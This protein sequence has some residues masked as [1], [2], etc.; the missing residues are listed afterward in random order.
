[1]RESLERS[2][3]A[4]GFLVGKN[5][6]REARVWPVL[7]SELTG[8]GGAGRRG[9][10]KARSG[11]L[12]GHRVLSFYCS[13]WVLVSFGDDDDVAFVALVALVPVVFLLLLLLFLFFFDWVILARCSVRVF[14]VGIGVAG[15]VDVCGFALVLPRSVLSGGDAACGCCSAQAHVFTIFFQRGRFG[16]A[17]RG[18]TKRHLVFLLSVFFLL[19]PRRNPAGYD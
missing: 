1:M 16:M 10:T 18:Q 19:V 5:N 7:C 2:G 4:G 13:V 8:V 17:K 12:G 15:V 14:V 11:V 9:G 6:P 3:K